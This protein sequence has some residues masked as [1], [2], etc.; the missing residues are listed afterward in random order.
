MKSAILITYNEEDVLNEARELCRSAGY[1]VRHI[2]QQKSLQRR[3]YGISEAVI[4][5]LEDLAAK[6]KPDVIVYD[7]NMKPSQN[8]NLASKLHMNILDR[9]ALILEIFERTFRSLH[10]LCQYQIVQKELLQIK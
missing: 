1:E 6:I 7:E 3:K 8:Y 2:I 4:E 10:Q 5:R 9:E